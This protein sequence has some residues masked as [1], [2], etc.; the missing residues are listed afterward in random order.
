MNEGRF[1]ASTGATINNFSYDLSEY[2]VEASVIS[3]IRFIGSEGAILKEVNALS[4]VYEYLGNEQYV[5]AR[6]ESEQGVAWTQPVFIDTL[7]D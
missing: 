2:T 6:I 3:N 7:R 1:Y 5:R 4:A